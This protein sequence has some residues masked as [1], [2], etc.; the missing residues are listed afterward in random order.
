MPSSHAQPD[1]LD[2]ETFRGV[3]PRTYRVS[4]PFLTDL[5]LVSEW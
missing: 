2:F 5:S 4:E 1:R 3:G